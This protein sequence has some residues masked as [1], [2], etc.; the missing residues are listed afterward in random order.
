MFFYIIYYIL[1]IKCNWNS[2]FLFIVIV[3]HQINKSHYILSFYFS[4]TEHYP[5]SVCSK[6]K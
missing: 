6:S 3:L 5:K 4:L 1:Y 2:N